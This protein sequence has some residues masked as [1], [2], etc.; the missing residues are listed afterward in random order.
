MEKR[1][2]LILYYEH[3]DDGQEANSGD[4]NEWRIA[5][6]RHLES[7]YSKYNANDSDNEHDEKRF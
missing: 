4:E 7:K 6:K 2:A 3:D 5:G 1:S